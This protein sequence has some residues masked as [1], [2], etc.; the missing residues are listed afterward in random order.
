MDRKQRLEKTTYC[1]SRNFTSGLEMLKANEGK[2]S[3]AANET[4]FVLSSHL[5]KVFKCEDLSE[6]DKDLA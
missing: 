6:R 4:F 5:H 3:K 1:Q 2:I